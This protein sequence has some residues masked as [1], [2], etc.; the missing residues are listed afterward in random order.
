MTMATPFDLHEFIKN[1]SVDVLTNITKA[2]WQSIA[3]AYEIR[4]DSRP[5]KEVLKN[6]VVESLVEQGVLLPEAIDKLTPCSSGGIVV[7]TPQSIPIDTQTLYEQRNLPQEE[8]LTDSLTLERYKL[9]CQVKMQQLSLE[10]ERENRRLEQEIRL[11]EL[12]V[13]ELQVRQDLE[14]KTREAK[15]EE[16]NTKFKP[17][18]AT[19]LL[20][21]FDECDV[22]GYF[23]T[24]ESLALR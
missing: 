4:V 9:E 19:S 24:F 23:R 5:T 1:P 14:I 15:K 22:D 8:T 10:H 21:P 3:S 12:T 16:T 11:R 6:M 7:T 2:H 17:S 13:K 18:E 20:P